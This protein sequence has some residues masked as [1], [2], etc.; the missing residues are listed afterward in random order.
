MLTLTIKGTPEESLAAVADRLG[1]ELPVE[2]VRT[3]D[4]GATVVV[5]ADE[6]LGHE[7][8]RWRAERPDMIPGFGYPVGTL[9][10]FTR[11]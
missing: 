2:E 9:L 10:L 11:S 3:L 7:V 1:S 5:L 6:P 8:N 4:L